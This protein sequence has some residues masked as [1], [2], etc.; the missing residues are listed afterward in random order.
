LDKILNKRDAIHLGRKGHLKVLSFLP[1]CMSILAFILDTPTNIIRGLYNIIIAPDILLTDYIAVGG[2]GAAFVNSAILAF[3]NIYILYKLKLKVNGTLIATTLTIMGFSFIGKNV[4]NIMPIYLGGYLYCK[5]QEIEFKNVVLVVMFGSTLAPLVSEIAFGLHVPV[6]IGIP[7]GII[8]GIIAGFVITP[9]SSHMVKVHDGY[10]LYNT[11]FTA[12]LLGSVITSILRGFGLIIEP[13][14][15]LS[16]DVDVLLKVIFITTFILLII[17]GYIINGRSF[18][19]Y[20]EILTYSGRLVTDFTQL[21][22]YGITYIN[23]GIMGL[24]SVTYVIISGGIMNGPVAAAILTVVGF[25][26]FGKHPK[27]A[28]PILIGVFIAGLTK[29]WHIDSTMVIIAGLFGTTLAPIAGAYGWIV[30]IITGFIHLSVVMNVG[31]LH[32]GINLYNNGFSGGIV[33]ALIVPLIDAFK[34]GD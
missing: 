8:F 32:G 23:M 24:I 21:T 19:G 25:S 11:G 28:I 14:Q 31:V 17:L 6:E 13:Q 34:K 16:S 15:V 20:K 18:K 7:L 30:G 9:L 10:N 2:V 22:S 3:V 1:I 26:A 27:N 12:G 5:Y 4:F 29:I 33:A